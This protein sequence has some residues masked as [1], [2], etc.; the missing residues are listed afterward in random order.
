V[1]CSNGRHSSSNT[2]VEPQER[3]NILLILFDIHTCG[4]EV[5][6]PSQMLNILIQDLAMSL[7]NTQ[8]I[9]T[10]AETLGETASSD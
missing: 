1:F 8:D 10:A 4:D 3:N 5:S 2:T 6:Q 9:Q 7:I